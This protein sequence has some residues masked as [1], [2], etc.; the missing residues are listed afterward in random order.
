MLYDPVTLQAKATL[1]FD[2]LL[3]QGERAFPYQPY[4]M[5][6][7]KTGNRL[8]VNLAGGG[9]G[10]SETWVFATQTAFSSLPSVHPTKNFLNISTR[11]R[12]E[13]GENVMIGGFI[14]QGTKPKKIVIRALGPSLPLI[15][16]IDNPLLELYDS[17]GKRIT[18]NDE[19]ISNRLNIVGTLLAPSSG[20]DSTLVVTLQPGAYTAIVRDSRNQNGVGL[21]EIYDVNTKD[22]RLANISTRAKAGTG[23]NVLI[24]GFIVGG[25]DPTKVLIRAVGPSLSRSGIRYPLI[26]P[27]LEL[28]D[29]TGKLI[30]WND[31]W[32]SAQDSLIY[33]TGLAPTDSREASM[34]LSLR[35]GNYTAIARGKGVATGV[36]LVEVYNLESAN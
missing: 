31:N 12:V 6:L 36:A 11:G 18:F 34:L 1:R 4:A 3:P 23:D 27:V 7:D 30:Y 8:F 21:V 28:H 14:I 33:A 24:G 32:R 13:T 5:T 29:G 26:D 17:N 10:A 20:R 2:G 19:W 35:P 9:S 22:S 15:G 16:A 25:N